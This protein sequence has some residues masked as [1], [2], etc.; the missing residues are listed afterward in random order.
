MAW[1]YGLIAVL[2]AAMIVDGLDMQLL[3]L[4]S[5]L[6][7]AD[8]GVGKADF[9]PAMSAALVGMSAGAVAG[10]WLG[11][12]V[13]RKTVLVGS[14]VVFGLATIFVSRASSV[15]AVA[16]LR[17]IGG[18]AYGATSPNSISLL[19]QWLPANLRAK[20]I[21]LL[22]IGTPVGGMLGAA[23]LAPLLPLLGWRGCFTVFGAVSAAM[24]LALWVVVP[25]RGGG[26]AK[27]TRVPPVSDATDFAV[28][29]RFRGGMWLAF[30]STTF[31]AYGLMA[32]ALPLTTMNGLPLAR[33][34]NAMFFFNSAALAG[35]V[36]GGFLITA[37]GSKRL[38]PPVA[39]IT[40]LGVVCL[41]LVL[42]PG[43][44]PTGAAAVVG[45]RLAATLI[46]GSTGLLLA[47][48][49]AVLA[50]GYPVGRR[51]AGVG[52]A[53]LVGRLGGIASSHFGGQLLGSTVADSSPFFAA[54]GLAVAGVVAGLLLVDQ[55]MPPAR[56]LL[57]AEAGT[58]P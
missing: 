33:G 30:F 2:V 29:W 26:G 6:M 28:S 24:A 4:V 40:G 31:V 1:E 45:F 18:F 23:L 25:G 39:A 37:L 49:Y 57:Q 35:A 51:A 53:M 15:A 27:G 50:Q 41:A 43:G 8:L 38:L 11:D 47:T 55:H 36:G 13:G 44:T 20:A 9:G 46:G 56:Q 54:L 22:P 19:S 5:P 17:A 32:W 48:M 52:L 16:A 21:S 3:S 12:R 7:M 14:V 34:L 42:G 10:G 58:A